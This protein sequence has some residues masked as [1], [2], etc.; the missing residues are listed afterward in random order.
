MKIVSTEVLDIAYLETGSPDGAPVVLLHGFPYDVRGYAGVAPPGARVIV[1]FLR[2]FGPTR[3]RSPDTM[4]S[5]QQAALGHDLLQLLDALGIARAVV[6]GYDWGGRAACVVAAL[7]PER[8][9]G[10]VTVGGYNI[11]DIAASAAEPESPAREKA[12]WY[13]H[14]FRSELGR[15]GLEQHREELCR[16]LW[17]DWSPTWERVDEEFARTAP[18]LHNPDFVDV[19]V[20]SY[21]HRYGDVPGDPRY[22]GMEERLARRPPITVPAVSLAPDSDGF[23]VNTP[24][25]GREQFT[26]PFRGHV[27]TSVGHNP[28]QEQPASFE[29]AISS[30]L[31]GGI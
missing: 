22:A 9:T 12:K 4:R 6:G 25:D 23:V 1:P 17:R 20:H 24:D 7:H 26:G 8:V 14:Y 31:S 29:A 10:L 28:P 15:R 2:G 27:L 11:Q 3:F 16:T 19:V 30:L 5:G 13:Q 18:S 21:R